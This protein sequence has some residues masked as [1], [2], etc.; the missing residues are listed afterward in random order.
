MEICYFE[1][2]PSD[3][4]SLQW[5]DLRVLLTVA[6]A[7][8]FSAAARAL[9]LGQ[10]TV[11]RRIARLEAQVEAPLFVRGADGAQPTETCAR[12]L[13][14]LER[15]AEAATEVERLALQNEPRPAGRVRVA[16]P[17]GLAVDFLA[18]FATQLHTRY[19]ELRLEVLAHLRV[20]DLARGE[21]DLSLRTVCPEARDLV[22]LAELETT[23]AAYASAAYVA[24]LPAT[25]GPADVDW[26]GWAPPFEHLAPNPQLAAL[27]PDFRPA[28]ASDDYLVQV[29]AAEAG[30]GA[31]ILPRIGHPLIEDRGLVELDLDLGAPKGSMH[32]VCAKSAYVVPRI[33]VV[34]DLL[35]DALGQT[36]GGR[37][38]PGG[39]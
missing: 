28:F 38:R 23:M 24:R 7:K 11:S 25:Y 8:S 19:P 34:A 30:A 2:V 12:L 6:E 10:P 37:V 17:P 32:L 9:G 4:E 5:D 35:I 3:F 39:G 36:D 29:R 1:I 33:R 20:L 22:C 18:P 16:A 31:M 26:I 15:M 21:A 14:A 27:V 13:P